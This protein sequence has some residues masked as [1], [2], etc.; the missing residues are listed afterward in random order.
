MPVKVGRLLEKCREAGNTDIMGWRPR[1]SGGGG[2]LEERVGEGHWVE[3]NT[4]RWG[5][6]GE[7][8]RGFWPRYW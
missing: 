5:L 2:I 8:H 7:R 3:M 1:V 6:C 4:G